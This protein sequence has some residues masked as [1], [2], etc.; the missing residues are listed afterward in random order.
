MEF[1]RGDICKMRSIVVFRGLIHLTYKMI[2]VCRV[3][4]CFVNNRILLKHH[5][6]DILE[7]L[8]SYG[9]CLGYRKISADYVSIHAMLRSK[10]GVR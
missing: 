7:I 6:S 8:H 4:S 2:G 5:I 3:F 1:V 9:V 10:R